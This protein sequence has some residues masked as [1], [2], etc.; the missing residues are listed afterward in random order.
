MVMGADGF[1]VTN[2]E[3]MVG[4]GIKIWLYFTFVWPQELKTILTTWDVE[5]LL[6]YLTFTH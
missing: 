1:S 4:Y 2:W 5:I 3:T 6:L